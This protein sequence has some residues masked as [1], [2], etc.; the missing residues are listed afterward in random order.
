MNRTGAKLSFLLTWTLAVFA[1]VSAF[2]VHLALRGRAL[3]LGYELGKAR[4]EQAKLF[5]VKRVLKL[6]AA[7]YKNPERVET[8]ARSVF[9]MSEPEPEHIVSMDR[10]AL[11]KTESTP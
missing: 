10:K 2:V 6:E 7:S 3:S 11:P 9:G 5:E 1:T 4:S 8:I